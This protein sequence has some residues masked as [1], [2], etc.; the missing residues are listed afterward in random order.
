MVVESGQRRDVVRKSEFG[1]RNS[2]TVKD[3]TAG[4]PNSQL[5]NPATCVASA[6]P[7]RLHSLDKMVKASSGVGS[8][9]RDD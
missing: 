4:L 2:E 7:L 3:G 8:M 6:N 9:E 5:L 1:G